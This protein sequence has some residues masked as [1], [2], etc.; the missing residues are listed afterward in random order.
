[1]LM[2]I[3][4]LLVLKL[5]AICIIQASLFLITH[6]LDHYK[7]K[8]S[9]DIIGYIC[10]IVEVHHAILVSKSVAHQLGIHATLTVSF[11]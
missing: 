1:M 6:F 9:F 3:H 5:D 10:L 4:F 8:I 2:T 7:R 11:A